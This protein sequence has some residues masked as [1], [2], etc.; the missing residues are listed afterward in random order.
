MSRNLPTLKKRQG[1]SMLLTAIFILTVMIFLA[2]TLQDI[3]SNSARSVAYEV[4][5]TRALQAANAGA[6][7]ALQLIFN[8]SVGGTPLVFSAA[9]PA[10]ATATM[11]Q[12]D[13]SGTPGLHGCT[14]DVSVSRF[15][16][17]DTD[18]FYNY[19]HY[20][21]DSSA[22]CVAGDFKTVRTVSVE[23]RER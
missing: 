22:T 12:L 1:G 16:V 17:T 23:G 13:V 4:Y 10:A 2:V 9:E 15:T 6:E 7:R 5:G 14:V 8:P 18:F 11:P 19:T 3:F 20:R 21:V